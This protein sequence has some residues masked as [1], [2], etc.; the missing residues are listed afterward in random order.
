AWLLES[1]WL[2]RCERDALRHLWDDHYLSRSDLAEW[3]LAPEATGSRPSPAAQGEAL[4]NLLIVTIESLRPSASDDVREAARY[5]RGYHVL[6]LTYVEEHAVDEIARELHISRRQ[7]FYDLK[8][9][10]EALA[11][12]LV[13]KRQSLLTR[14]P[15]GT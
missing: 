1:G 10:L 14:V 6:Q 11:D 2:V 8:E 3:I 4:R 13:R 15:K 7:Y 9:A 12:A 5:G